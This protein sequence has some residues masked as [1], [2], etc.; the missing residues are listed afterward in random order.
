M[1]ALFWF[2]TLAALAIGVALLG[3]LTDGYVLWVLPPWRIEMSFNLFVLLQL[4]ILLVVYLLLRLLINTLRLPGVVAAYRARRA[5][6]RRERAASEMLRLFWEGRYSQ[7]LKLAEKF[8]DGKVG[9]GETAPS[10]RS[11]AMTA[12]I[13][14]L[15]ALKAAHALHD[16]QRSARWQA[17]AAELDETGW[18]TARL[19]AEMRIA[20]DGRDFTAARAALEQLGP[21]ERRRISVQRLAL[22]LAQGEGDWAEVLRLARLLEKH[23]ALTVDQARPLR[24][25][26][27]RGLIEA[28]RD[29][30]ARLARHWRGMTAEE[31]RD[32]QLARQVAHL[33]AAAGACA[34]CA[35]LVEEFLDTQW[36]PALLAD[37][38]ACPSGDVL[39]RIANGE[40]W[41]GV[42]PQ[43][44]DLLLALGRLCARHELWGKAQSYLEAA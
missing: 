8:A 1:R 38:A 11:D 16:P 3:R 12:G 25:A 35:E 14:A 6:Q 24:L 27:Q 15:V 42:H 13:I 39:G 34:E 26:A 18:R 30:P 10:R 2:L 43:D 21:K 20:L 19:L 22:R 37:Y 7:V 29:D 40:K 28:L 36:E 33:L 41:L 9:A 17:R 32:P 23:H 31:R 5:R 44:A 4:A